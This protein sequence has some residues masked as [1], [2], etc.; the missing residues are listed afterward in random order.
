MKTL[1][2]V[3]AALVMVMATA[4]AQTPAKSAANVGGTW[5]V[6][7]KGPAAHGDMQATMQ[8]KQE[9][10]AVT[11]TFSVHGTEH[12]LKGQFA[13]ATLTL[14]STDTPADKG[15]TFTAKLKDDGSLAGY[16]S[17]PMGDMQWTATRAAA[18]Q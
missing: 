13:D 1:T 12:T 10:K 6:A 2:T 9:G 7:V 4:S 16:V 15:L 5:S 18:Q 3:C 8:L 11:G 14:E 17:G